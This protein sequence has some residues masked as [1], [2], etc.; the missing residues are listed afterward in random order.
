MR[1]PAILLAATISTM[2]AT[3]ALAHRQWLLPSTTTV[4]GTSE[5]VT[6]DA[7]VSNDLF[8]ADHMAM[9]PAQVS[10]WTPDGAPATVENGAKG[11]YRGTFDVAINKSGTWKIG[12]ERTSVMG[13]FMLNGEQ[14]RVG[15]RGRPAGAPGAPGGP[16]APAMTPAMAP[17]P[18]GGPGAGAPGGQPMR[19]VATPADIPAG[20]TD[21]KLTET[22]ARNFIYVTSDA[23]TR[24]VLA[25]VGKGL[26]F[27]PVSHP[28]ELV[29]NEEATFRFL[30][31]GKPAAGINIS[32]VPGGKKYREAEDAQELVTGADGTIKVKW[33]V[34]GW[35]WLN[36]NAEDTNP[37]DKR[38]SQRRM[39]FTTTLEVVAP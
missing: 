9:D 34:A 31:D 1:F 25:P 24:T 35:Y 32:L 28:D 37:T 10:A 27:D 3:P 30:V 36:A 33:P 19:S 22:L 6:V 5:Y 17:A 23:P 4:A 38:A 8:Y 2:L 15:G 21:V 20:A 18:A 13:T 11:R 39:S 29:S 26:E 12:M 16:G 7:A 14:W